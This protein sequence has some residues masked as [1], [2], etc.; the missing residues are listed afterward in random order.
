MYSGKSPH[1]ARLSRDTLERISHLVGIFKA[2][3]ILLPRHEAADAWMKR[4]NDA[5]LFKGQSALEYVLSG[6]LEDLIAVRRYLDAQRG[7]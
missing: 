5:S 6:T 2:L 1:A 4:A 7:W 3:G